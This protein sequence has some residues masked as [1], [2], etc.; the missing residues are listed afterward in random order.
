MKVKVLT[1]TS[2]KG[3]CELY[4]EIHGSVAGNSCQ[5]ELAKKDIILPSSIAVIFYKAGSRTSVDDN[6]YIKFTL[7]VRTSIDDFNAKTKVAVLQESQDWEAPQVKDL[8]LVIPEYYTFMA[9]NTLFIALGILDK[10]LKKATPNKSTMPP[11][12]YKTSLVHYLPQ[13]HYK[14]IVNKSTKLKTS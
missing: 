12:S 4:T 3:H 9:S 11:G 1:Y 5:I 14:Y 10:Y 7:S 8:K 2:Y 6:K 13:N